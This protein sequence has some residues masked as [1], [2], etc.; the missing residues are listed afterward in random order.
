M[1]RTLAIS[2]T[3]LLLAGCGK[4]PESVDKTAAVG[5]PA[6]APVVA[7]PV[8]FQPGKWR[9]TSELVR[10]EVPGM[11][12]ELAK[13]NVGQ[14]TSFDSCMTPE[15][16]AKPPSKFFTNANDTSCTTKSFAMVGGR[17]DATMTCLNKHTPGEMTMTIKG[18][19]QPASYT[20]TMTM[21][22]DGAPGGGEMK[23]IAT[24]S[25]QRVGDCD[26]KGG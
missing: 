21:V 24:T 14:K 3:L 17:L 10:M 13:R 18:D 15:Q 23:I 7:A 11:P 22:T 9:Q 25:G 26:A 16:A 4:A 8:R 12:P 1:H 6:P 2:A 5:V 20:A 19:Y